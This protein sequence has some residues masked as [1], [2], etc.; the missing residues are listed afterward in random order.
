MKVHLRFMILCV[1]CAFNW[2]S[3]AYQSFVRKILPKV[4][5]ASNRRANESPFSPLMK[6]RSQLNMINV[7][8][9]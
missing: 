5:P 4:Y 3:L 6:S 9:Q 2:F 7:R 8:I 1:S